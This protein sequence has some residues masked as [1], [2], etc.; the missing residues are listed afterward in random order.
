MKTLVK[1]QMGQSE[2]QT[3]QLWNI[4]GMKKKLLNA[5]EKRDCV[6]MS[7]FLLNKTDVFWFNSFCFLFLCLEEAGDP[8]LRKSQQKESLFVTLP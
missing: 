4:S 3:V 7:I 6:K 5:F 2:G 1:L 8:P